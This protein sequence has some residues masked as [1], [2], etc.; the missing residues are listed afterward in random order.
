M[1]LVMVWQDI[2]YIFK[3]TQYSYIMYIYERER[4]P[5]RHREKV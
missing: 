2:L 1:V 4:Q 3:D 5:E